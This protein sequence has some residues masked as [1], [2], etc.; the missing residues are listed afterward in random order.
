M[1]RVQAVLGALI[2]SAVI[3]GTAMLVLVACTPVRGDERICGPA[4]WYGAEHHGGIT[5]SGS[6]FDQWAMTA[7]MASRSHLGEVWRVTYGKKSV[8]VRIT[9]TG[10]FA[11]YGRIIDLSRGAFRKLADEGK[12]VLPVCLEKL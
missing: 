6:R 5:A 12:G 2:G 11:K 4:S 10:G 3:I 8:V 7:A 1:T 9:D